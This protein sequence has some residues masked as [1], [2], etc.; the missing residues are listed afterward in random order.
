MVSGSDSESC[1]GLVSSSD[2][3][4]AATR[5][6]LQEEKLKDKC[7]SMRNTLQ[8]EK[9][10]RAVQWMTS[11][12]ASTASLEQKHAATRKTMQ[13]EKLKDKCDSMRNT[14]QEEKLKDKCE[15][16]GKDTI[17]QPAQPVQQ[18]LEKSQLAENDKLEAKQKELKAWSPGS[19]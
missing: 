1:P 19:R 13:E 11:T 8:E 18:I 16:G 6:T 3:D 4:D 7:D 10:R 12:A 2:S 5:N 9:L 17:E 14:L 15:T